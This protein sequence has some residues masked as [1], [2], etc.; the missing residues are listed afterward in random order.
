MLSEG[1]AGQ[2]AHNTANQAS[3]SATATTAASQQQPGATEHEVDPGTASHGA[4]P[5]MQ[6]RQQQHGAGWGQYAGYGRCF[7]AG[8][9]PQLYSEQYT[10]Q[11][12]APGIMQPMASWSCG[13]MQYW[14]PAV[15]MVLQPAPGYGYP[16]MPMVVP[17]G[18]VVLATPISPHMMQLQQQHI[19]HHD[20]QQRRM[21]RQ[22]PHPPYP[23][24]G[25]APH[26]SSVCAATRGRTTGSTSN[27]KIS[28]S[29]RRSSVSAACS[30]SSDFGSTIADDTS[31]ASLCRTASTQLIVSPRGSQSTALPEGVENLSWAWLVDG[32]LQQVVQFLTGHNSLQSFRGTCRHWKAV[33]DQN[34]RQLAPSCL[35]PKDLVSL[36][37]RLQVLEL[38]QCPNV[39]NRDLYV[40]AQSPI[41]LRCLTLGDDTN[42]P[43]VTNKGLS[44][45]GRM[46]S[47]QSLALHDCNSIT[48]NGMTAL[49]GL[50]HL[51]SLSLRG[52]RKITNNGLEVL[53]VGRGL[54]SG[55]L[56]MVCWLSTSTPN[57]TEQIYEMLLVSW[58]L[59]AGNSTAAV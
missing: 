50:Q 3:S 35:K 27:G 30:I 20:Q 19:Q 42:K 24:N 5:A 13:P 46:S 41:Q 8:A 55:P 39:R 25:L 12:H 16:M 17:H 49:S 43:W 7:D 4:Q 22:P 9:D 38:V 52:C 36:F 29:S 21:Q 57:G 40:L 18:T 34:I 56:G 14:K 33:A 59:Q 53:Q 37:P 10:E 44:S 32:I 51:S 15:P 11:Y 58:H 6:Y 48:N 2:A 54:L 47:L 23:P 28:S 31:I 26:H 45:I 1:S